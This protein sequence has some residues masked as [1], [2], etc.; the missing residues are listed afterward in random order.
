M[1]GAGPPA[2]SWGKLPKRCFLLSWEKRIELQLV[3]PVGIHVILSTVPCA[4]VRHPKDAAAS[5]PLGLS[6]GGSRGSGGVGRVLDWSSNRIGNSQI[7]L[8]NEYT[9]LCRNRKNADRL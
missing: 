9:G 7:T 8:K 1:S 6:W 5:R 2:P 4:K 3:V